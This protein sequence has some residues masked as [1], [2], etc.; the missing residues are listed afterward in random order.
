MQNDFIL[1]ARYGQIEQI[2]FKV[3]DLNSTKKVFFRMVKW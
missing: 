3:S 2:R 1:Y